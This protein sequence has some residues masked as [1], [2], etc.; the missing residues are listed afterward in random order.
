MRF[1]D[2]TDSE[3]MR[4]LVDGLE[5]RSHECP[6]CFLCKSPGIELYAGL[7]DRLFGAP[8][9]WKMKQCLNLDC[10]LLWLDPMPLADDIGVA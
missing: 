9:V 8:G 10:G 7:T 5:I 6:Q 2:T 3:N 1:P 4:M